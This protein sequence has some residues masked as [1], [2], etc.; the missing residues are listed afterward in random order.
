MGTWNTMPWTHIAKKP[1]CLVSCRT[2]IRPVPWRTIQH[3]TFNRAPVL[4][5]FGIK[6]GFSSHFYLYLI[7]SLM[8]SITRWNSVSTLWAIRISWPSSAEVAFCWRQ[9]KKVRRSFCGCVHVVFSYSE[10]FL[11]RKKGIWR[12]DLRPSVLNLNFML[13]GGF[14]GQQ[15]TRTN[16]QK[17]AQIFVRQ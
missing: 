5:N 3:V 11:P 8:E 4:N 14:D 1:G 17:V 10:Q 2:T 12:S 16:T 7:F 13:F 6:H 9:K 15:T